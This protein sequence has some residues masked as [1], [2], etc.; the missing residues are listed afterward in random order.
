MQPCSA[1][2]VLFACLSLAAPAS[3]SHATPTS[4]V[5]RANSECGVADTRVPV[6]LQRRCRCV[7]GDCMCP[8]A[9]GGEGKKP[10]PR[11][12]GPGT[13]SPSGR[14]LPAIALSGKD[15]VT[16]TNQSCQGAGCPPGTVGWPGGTTAS[17]HPC[18]PCSAGKYNP[19][20]NKNAGDRV[21]GGWGCASC[22]EPSWF[23]T[24]P[25]GSISAE[26]CTCDPSK[27][28]QPYANCSSGCKCFDNHREVKKTTC[29]GKH[30][31]CRT[32]YFCEKC[33]EGE[34]CPPTACVGSGTGGRVNSSVFVVSWLLLLTIASQEQWTYETY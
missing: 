32:E 11:L 5:C 13:S 17:P 29:P 12:C 2:L 34:E 27:L 10:K 23:K 6:H 33:V 1:Y 22:S 15:T 8:K 30:N 24:S 9:G 20:F 26:Q 19:E 21:A 31:P 18:V 16:A 7:N 14:D 4:W 28:V 25:N 3:A